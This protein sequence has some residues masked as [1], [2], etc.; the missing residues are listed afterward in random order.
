MRFVGDFIE[1]ASPAIV[2]P[3]YVFGLFDLDEQKVWPWSDVPALPS[4]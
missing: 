2:S 3:D 1:A 4:R